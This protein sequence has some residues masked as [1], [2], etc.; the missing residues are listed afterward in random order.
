MSQPQAEI[1]LTLNDLTK[2]GHN[3]AGAW[4]TPALGDEAKLGSRRWRI[5][6][7]NPLVLFSGPHG[8]STPM[9]DCE[10]ILIVASGFGIAAHLPYLNRLIHGYNTRE[11]CARRIHPLLRIQTT[12]NL[13]FQ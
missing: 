9:D 2:R 13:E 11:V 8:K 1:F 7:V 5:R 6:L 4:G 3:I 12:Y 10:N